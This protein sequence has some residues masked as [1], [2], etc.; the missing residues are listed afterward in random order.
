MKTRVTNERGVAT[1]V[2]LLM[3]GMLLLIGL[4]ALST[5]DDEIAIAGNEKQ[6]MRA[7]YAAEAGLEQA[8]AALEVEFDSTGQPPLSLPGGSYAV[9]GCQGVYKTVD[10][11]AAE[12]K[13]LTSGT[14][15]GLHALV[16][17]YTILGSATS[18]LA[19]ASVV[20]S[21]SFETA[22]VPIF[23]FAVFYE[24]D[25][26]TTPIYDM[27]IDGRVHVNGDMYLQAF[28]KLSFSSRVSAS[29]GI[30]H[31]L[32]NGMSSGTTGDVQ[33][34]DASGNMVSM[35]E[36]SGWL[37]ASDSHWH[38]SAAGRWQGMV[39]DESFGQQELKLPLTGSSDAHKIIERASGNPDSYENKAGLKI[40]DGVPYVYSGSNWVDVSG[41]L[42][43]GTITEVKFYDGREQKEVRSTEIDMDKLSTSGYM[44]SNGVIY[45]SD[46]RSGYYNGLRLSNGADIGQ[47]LSVFS[48]N[49]VYVQGDF[50]T[51]DKQPVAVA[52][53]CV[54]FLSN[55]WSD[56]DSYKNLSYRVPSATT[57][58][59][60]LISGDDE[61]TS[62][63]YG[64]GLENLPRFLEDWRSKKFTLRGSL[65]NLWRSRQA[66]GA[67]SYGSYYT[68]PTRD[69]GF[70]S[71]FNDPNKL[72][73]ETPAVRTFFRTGWQQQYVNFEVSD[74]MLE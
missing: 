46:R 38:D 58:N 39:S 21:Q 23:Q 2:A 41:S 5:T 4:A 60:A 43:S 1:L 9:N 44:P 67:W 53:D 59:V 22:L 26:W 74:E 27:D 47:P 6:E 69:W 68:A 28:T 12:T 73:P 29:G 48:E 15:A 11:G 36:G 65:I 16:K 32:P 35:K 3:I 40:I 34:K 42:P 71:D 55:D 10:G 19:D 62:S 52:G 61:P 50:N 57:V 33:F 14:L 31:G 17:S 49:P 70:D 7:F 13:V 18:D 66:Q 25:L 64:G 20:L 8:A 72:P 37:E 54:T 63:N 45:S 56:A 30:Y 24:N 51:T